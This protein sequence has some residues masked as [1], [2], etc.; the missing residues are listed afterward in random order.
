VS[1]R[2]ETKNRWRKAVAW[3][4]AV[5]LLTAVFSPAAAGENEKKGVADAVFEFYGRVISPVDGNRCP[6]YPSC[7]HYAKQSVRKH[8]LLAGWVMAMDRVAR[9]GRDEKY[10]SPSRVTGRNRY[11]YDPVENNDFW[12]FGK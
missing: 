8:G 1:H 5:L 3:I 12:W 11:I 9:C 10:V 2:C 7:A 4:V 6:M